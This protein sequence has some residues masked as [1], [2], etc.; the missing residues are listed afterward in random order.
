MKDNQILS[1]KQ[2][3]IHSNC[4]VLNIHLIPT[5]NEAVILNPGDRGRGGFLVGVWNLFSSFFGGGT[6]ILRA[7]FMAYKVICLK[8]FWI[9]PSIRD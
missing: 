8:K 6:N 7:I 9:K 1:L 3:D 4:Y 5:D 2:H